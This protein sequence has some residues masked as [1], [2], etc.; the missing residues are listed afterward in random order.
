VQRTVAMTLIL[1]SITVFLRHKTEQSSFK[2][3]LMEQYLREHLFY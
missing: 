1:V 2:P 3:Y